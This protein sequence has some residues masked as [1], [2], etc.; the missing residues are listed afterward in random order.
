MEIQSGVDGVLLSQWI[1]SSNLVFYFSCYLSKEIKI[2]KMEGRAEFKLQCMKLKLIA[3]AII[4]YD[5]GN[6]SWIL[7]LGSQNRDH[8]GKYDHTATN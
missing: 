8:L 7:C 1:K 5:I 6:K 4:S 2:L 3:Q